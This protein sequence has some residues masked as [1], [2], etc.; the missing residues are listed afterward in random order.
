MYIY[1]Y[2]YRYIYIY[3][4]IYDKS[5]IVH[6]MYRSAV[7]PP[8]VTLNRSFF[9]GIW[10]HIIFDVMYCNIS[11]DDDVYMNEITRRKLKIQFHM[12]NQKETEVQEGWIKYKNGIYMNQD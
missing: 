11:Y 1:I 7:S 2:V 5:T 4:Y 6:W 12:N 3:I 10:T 9:N 8:F